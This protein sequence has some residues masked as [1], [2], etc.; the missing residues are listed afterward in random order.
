MDLVFFSGMIM[1]LLSYPRMFFFFFF[2]RC[3]LGYLRG[4]FM[5]SAT[6]T[7]MAKG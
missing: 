5:M 2:S 1:V 6:Y 7:D 4:I 3:I